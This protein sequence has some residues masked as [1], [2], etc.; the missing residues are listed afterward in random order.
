MSQG[1]KTMKRLSIIL[2]T[3]VAAL[4]AVANNNGKDVYSK[5][6]ATA[7]GEGL[8]YAIDKATSSPLFEEESVCE[9]G[10][11]I[12]SGDTDTHSFHLYAKAKEGNLFKG[13]FSDPEFTNLISA[14]EHCTYSITATSG[15]TSE[16][17]WAL[18]G[19]ASVMTYSRVAASIATGTGTGQIA[20]CASRSETPEYTTD[21]IE[22][23]Q[24]SKDNAMHSY[25]LY[26][27]PSE[28]CALEG[29]YSDPECTQFL[30]NAERYTYTVIAH[31]ENEEEPTS[32]PVYARFKY[33]EQFLQLENSGFEQWEGVSSG[34]EPV[35]WSSFVTA[36]GSGIAFSQATKC[37]IDKKEDAHSGQY[38]AHIW[39]RSVFG[40]VAQGNLTSG[41]INAGSTSPADASG[42]YN[43]TRTSEPSQ[44]M[45]FNGRPDQMKV[46]IKS[47]VSGRCNVAVKLHA[48]GYYQDPIAREDQLAELIASAKLTPESN[49]G[50]WTE[51]TIPFDYQSKNDP[52]YALVTFST[53]DTPGSGSKTDEMWIDDV[54]MI[55]FSELQSATYDGGSLSFDGEGTAQVIGGYNPKLLS[56]VSTG[57]GAKISADFDEDTYLLTIT[58]KGQDYQQNPENVHEYYVQFTE[59]TINPEKPEQPGHD[60]EVNFDPDQEPLNSHRRLNGISFS[61]DESLPVEF[62]VDPNLCYQDLRE[63]AELQVEPEAVVRMALDYSD[64]EA[65][66]DMIWMHSY[67]YVDKDNDGRFDV[68]YETGLGDLLAYS[69]YSFDEGHDASGWN[70]LGEEIKGDARAC[71]QCPEFTVPAEP[72]IYTMRVKIDWNSLDPAGSLGDEYDAYGPNGIITNGGYIVDLKLKV[73][74]PV[75]EGI[76]TISAASA[77]TD[78][79]FDLTGRSYV[80][81]PKFGILIQGGKKVIK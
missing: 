80:R 63:E 22:L 14:R 54:E 75:P 12:D 7:S 69:F 42:N 9:Q 78:R 17:V 39:A 23:T 52:Y 72:G 20:L 62:S 61:E 67:V 34:E 3:L 60:Y 51:Y 16:Q 76:G 24:G 46:W 81:Q 36:T 25:V 45:R 59:G 37:Q 48:E 4:T 15:T 44:S 19:D 49:G 31:S 10:S 5:L 56:V 13:W 35:K 64:P 11:H 21:P 73:G 1:Q 33:V 68:D 18:F 70:S 29:W 41:C 43:Y 40:V 6:T 53:S 57:A 58:I 71:V 8:V 47:N 28:N 32:Y 38:S 79:Y 66:Y 77:T 74:D 26:A 30:S 50:E 2:C 27:Q 65:A 55:Y